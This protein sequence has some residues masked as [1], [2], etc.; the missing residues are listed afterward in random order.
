MAL[1]PRSPFSSAHPLA[2][3]ITAGVYTTETSRPR[4]V[5]H[6]SMAL[7]EMPVVTMADRAQQMF[8]MSDK[9]GTRVYYADNGVF[10][11]VDPGGL[12]I[13]FIAG[14][15][16]TTDRTVMRFLQFFVEKR[17]IHYLELQE[18]A[19]DARQEDTVSDEHERSQGSDSG[20]EEPNEP[21]GQESI[22]R[23]QITTDTDRSIGGGEPVAV[24]QSSSRPAVSSQ[25]GDGDDSQ[26]QGRQDNPD[27]Q[28]EP[29]PVLGHKQSLRD[30]LKAK[31]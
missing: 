4:N 28:P 10:N 18:D 5:A 7:Q 16:K 1:D 11:T 8:S 19:N 30:V 20:S 13:N 12:A 27:G 24:E 26:E 14:L 21:D 15:F 3:K 23:L 31:S 6:H 29:A 25:P 22:G 2:G 17:A 9:K